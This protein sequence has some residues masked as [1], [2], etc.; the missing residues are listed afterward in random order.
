MEKVPKGFK[1]GI[2][3]GT[4]DPIHYGHLVAAEA[5][6]AEFNL[7]QVI[8]VPT[9]RPPH[10]EGLEISDAK[11]RL[12]MTTLATLTN[13]YFDV[14]RVDIDRPG[15]TYT[16]DTI[17]DLRQIYGPEAALYFITGADALL[18]ILSWKDAAELVNKCQFIAASRP[19]YSLGQLENALGSFFTE[20]RR[21]FHLLEVPALAISSTDIRERVRS[22]RPIQYL[23]PETV[24][25]Y[26]M[27][28]HLY[29]ERSA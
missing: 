2:M 8:F 14:S 19:G 17:R 11:D 9:G 25:Y 4:F 23:L 1:V 29:I 13:P 12:L 5:A 6:R 26:I 7:Q 21:V 15:L 28:N 18:E 3:G 20:N 16:I 24:A 10:K 27:K 22:G